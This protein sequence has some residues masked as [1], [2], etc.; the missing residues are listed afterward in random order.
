MAI[1]KLCRA[2]VKIGVGGGF[3]CVQTDSKGINEWREGGSHG[4]PLRR[5]ESWKHE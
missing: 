3:D 4:L 2:D 1:I 5:R